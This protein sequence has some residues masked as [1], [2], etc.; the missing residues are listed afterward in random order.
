MH[1]D[2]HW[3][4][5]REAPGIGTGFHFHD[6][7][8]TCASYLAKQGRSLLGIAN[9]P[10]HKTLAMVKRYARLVD[11]YKAKVIEKMIAAKGI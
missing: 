9:V 7:R 10:G 4:G 6:L 8:H 5:E 1:F 2:A 3:Y 11:D